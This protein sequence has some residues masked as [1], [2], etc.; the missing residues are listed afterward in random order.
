MPKRLEEAA[1]HARSTLV[2][3]HRLDMTHCASGVEGHAL[4]PL[5]SYAHAAVIAQM[6]VQNAI[7]AIAGPA[8]PFV[9]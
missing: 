3:A 7:V 5:R 8:I 2:N 6:L 4:P 1:N 9:N